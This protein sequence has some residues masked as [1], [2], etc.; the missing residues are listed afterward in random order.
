MLKSLPAV[1]SLSEPSGLVN[2]PDGWTLLPVAI[3]YL[4]SDA[5]TFTMVASGDLTA[6]LSLGM[7]LKLR[8]SAG[9]KYFIVSQLTYANGFTSISIYGGTDYTLVNEW[10]RD[11]YYSFWYA[12]A[13]FVL[14]SDKWLSKFSQGSPDAGTQ[15]N[16]VANTWYN[17]GSV[18]LTIPIG[19]WAVDYAVEAT[20]G[21]NPG[22]VTDM[23]ITLSTTNNGETHPQL[24]S[25]HAYTMISG[26]LQIRSWFTREQDL[27]FTVKTPMFLN[28]RT[29]QSTVGSIF[30]SSSQVRM[31][32][33][34]VSRYVA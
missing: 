15:T 20:F 19:I 17:A 25:R 23:S 13:G 18:G 30:Y 34:A 22:T 7:R 4:N 24:T 21:K 10:I 5:P 8:Q 12:P 3:T 26:N 2:G 16:P 27:S 6:M 28:I 14:E 9:I 31:S 1:F 11:V 29:N 33:R 32:I